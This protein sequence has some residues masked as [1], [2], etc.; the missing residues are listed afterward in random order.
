M[1]TPAYLTGFCSL[2]ILGN[3]CL[4][5]A[6]Q[7]NTS[8]STVTD[9]PEASL[10][11]TLDSIV[12]GLD[13]ASQLDQD[14]ADL[15][16]VLHQIQS[17]DGASGSI[18]LK[19]ISPRTNTTMGSFSYKTQ[20]MSNLQSLG[21]QLSSLHS[22]SQRSNW[23][24]F[25]NKVN[26]IEAGSLLDNRLNSFFS[27]E[28]LNSKQHET[29]YEAGFS[30]NV[31][32]FSLG[33]DYRVNNNFFT[34]AILSYFN[35]DLD[36]VNQGG[37]LQANNQSL[38]AYANFYINE[39]FSLGGVIS[40]GTYQYSLARKINLNLNNIPNERTASSSP[41]GSFYA[42]QASAVYSKH[43][44]KGL[45]TNL[46]V[47]LDFVDSQISTFD[48][49]GAGGINLHIENF[50][51]Q[52]MSLTLGGQASYVASTSWAV[53]TPFVGVSWVYDAMEQDQI[54]K[55]HFISDPNKTPFQFSIKDNDNNYLHFN[56]GTG[57]IFARGF[58][59]FFQF[60]GL[61]LRENY[62]QYLLSLGI[63][64]EF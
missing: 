55:A 35:A 34:G 39:E 33:S 27:A 5:D 62:N 31:Q 9:S 4:A 10:N 36:V 18:A 1:K 7:I 41:D 22:R 2:L 26:A 57:A 16:N 12:N 54:V 61:Y 15:S 8:V 51:T 23:R 6:I 17:A 20:Y 43:V 63:R 29:D 19:E 64:K 30:G 58:S 32:R 52:K 45:T 3:Q 11:Y 14:A 28:Q 40:A 46:N 21:K 24:S 53:L 25:R 13:S 49:S 60:D 50:S 42:A 48:E 59:G 56:L 38:M 44:L 37:N 47:D